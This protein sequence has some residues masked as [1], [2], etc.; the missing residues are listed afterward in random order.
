[1]RAHHRRFVIWGTLGAVLL[2]GLFHAFRPR[3]VLVDMATATRGELVVTVDED[4]VTRVRDVFLLSAPIGGRALRI[5]AEVGD[6]VVANR[7]VIA[8]IEPTDPAFL[9]IRSRAE[10]EAA[11]RA[12][13]AAE[14]LARAALS[15]AEAEYDFAKA[16]LDRARRLIEKRTIPERTLDEAIRAYRTAAAAVEEAKARLAM[17]RSDLERARARLLSPV[18]RTGRR[19]GCECVPVRAPVSGRI[20]RIFHESEGVVQAG[21]PLV[22]IGDPRD[23]EIVAD[24]LSSDAVRVGPGQAVLIEDWGGDGV[25]NGR[26]R[27]VEPYAFTKVSALG[28][29]EQRVNVII[30]FTDPPERWARLGHGYRVEVRIVVWRGED[31]LR[32]P[33]GALFRSGDGWAVFAVEDGRARLRPVETGHST[34]L[35]TEIVAGLDEGARVVLHPDERIADGVRVAPRP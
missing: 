27:R 18:E 21:E 13:E 3:P 6:E 5:E 29:E 4:G 8:R 1:M 26:V 30:D 22:E 24:L 35:E 28:I 11:V 25:L 20:L 17:R 23:L 32:I 2:A 9:D 7:T 15:R 14:A 31:V 34:G 16:E 19:D 10:A 33:Q 12:A